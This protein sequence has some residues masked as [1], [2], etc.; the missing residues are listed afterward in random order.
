M[1]LPGTSPLQIEGVG[2]AEVDDHL[3]ELPDVLTS[4]MPEFSAL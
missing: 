2:T 4:R 1:P 3:I